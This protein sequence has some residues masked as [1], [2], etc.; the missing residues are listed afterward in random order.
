LLA[1]WPSAG[2]PPG[3]QRRI[4]VTDEQDDRSRRDDRLDRQALAAAITTRMDEL[5]IGQRELADRAHVSVS[6]LRNMQNGTGDSEYSYGTLT[7]VSKALK[8]PAEHLHRLFHRLP[9]QDAITPSGAEVLTQAVMAELRPYLAKID[10]MAANLS[11][12]ME[13][14]HTI[15]NGSGIDVNVPTPPAEHLSHRPSEDQP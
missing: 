1:Y 9:E 4:A 13:F 14:I 8:Y 15:N 12:V 11:I 7:R 3:G 5:G 2:Q 10:A 6:Y